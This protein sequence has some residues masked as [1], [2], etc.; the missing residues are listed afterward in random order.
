MRSD[1]QNFH[2][3]LTQ[4]ALLPALYQDHR[5]FRLPSVRR[6]KKTA[7]PVHFKF[8]MAVA[9]AAILTGCSGSPRYFAS[10]RDIFFAAPYASNAQVSNLKPEDFPALVKFTKLRELDFEAPSC[11]DAQLYALTQVSLP[12]LSCVVLIGCP[13]I[14]DKGIAYLAQI[15]A[16][17]GLGLRD[18]AITD[19]SLDILVSM[20]K[21]QG[22]TLW[23]STNISLNGLLRLAQSDHIED[24]G[25]SCGD[26]TQGDLLRIL[27]VSRKLN[28]III[29][30]PPPG[31]LDAPTLRKAAQAKGIKI[32]VCHN[33]AVSAL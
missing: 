24:I 22:V 30:E 25:F 8:L 5:V 17:D 28:R 11:T 13:L 20:P 6:P 19:R 18:L 23:G 21:L 14:T 31:R 27:E 10:R 33:R 1:G 12:K 3:Q 32:Y 4:T 29:D 9:L 2:K 7:R 16:I 15:P 26:L